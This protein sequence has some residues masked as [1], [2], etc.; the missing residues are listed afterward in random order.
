MR[1][2]RAQQLL[3]KLVSTYASWTGKTDPFDPENLATQRYNVTNQQA[4]MRKSVQSANAHDKES[5]MH[6]ARSQNIAPKEA[7]SQ[8]RIRGERNYD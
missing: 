2:S 3:E 4:A 1:I 7:W 5:V 8:W 6:I